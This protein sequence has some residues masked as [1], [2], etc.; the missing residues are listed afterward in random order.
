M[1]NYSKEIPRGLIQKLQV[2]GL[3]PSDIKADSGDYR[4]TIKDVTQLFIRSLPPEL[5]EDSLS[6]T[7]GIELEKFIGKMLKS[8][9]IEKFQDRL[10]FDGHIH[11]L[12][13]LRDS[14]EVVKRTIEVKKTVRPKVEL[15]E[16]PKEKSAKEIILDVLENRP[17]AYR[18][19]YDFE[20]AKAIELENALLIIAGRE[21][22]AKRLARE[23]RIKE[24]G[25]AFRTQNDFE[26][27]KE[28]ELKAPR[29]NIFNIL[30]HWF[31]KT[32]YYTVQIKEI[33]YKKIVYVYVKSPN[34]N[35]KNLVKK[36]IKDHNR[37]IKIEIVDG[38]EYN[39]TEILIIKNSK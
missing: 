17:L 16:L 20:K 28:L 23:Q 26:H 10:C 2:N 24:R 29:E 31:S 15:P 36:I 19:Q 21:A 39:N 37:H 4:I 18:T 33:E 22:E 1:E 6:I 8:S 35:M 13:Y 12:K 25:Y 34:V 3:R 30:K 38:S 14:C 11:A 5:V 7:D 27:D 32:R 9:D